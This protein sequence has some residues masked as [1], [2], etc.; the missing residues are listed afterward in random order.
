M[1]GKIVTEPPRPSADILKQFE[2]IWTSTISDA[3][4]RHGVMDP[5][6]QPLFAPVN[7]IGVALTIINYPND[8]ITTHRALQ[9]ARPGDILVMLS[10]G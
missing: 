7:V 2:G 8:N 3:M 1:Y 10:L 6:I 9:M 4:G 5:D